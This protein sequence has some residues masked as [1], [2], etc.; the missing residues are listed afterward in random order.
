MEVYWT[1]STHLKTPVQEILHCV[2][3]DD[4]IERVIYLKVFEE[5]TIF[6]L[7][8]SKL[9][10]AHP[11]NYFP[12]FLGKNIKNC[13]PSKLFL[14]S[15]LQ[16]SILYRGGNNTIRL[17]LFAVTYLNFHDLTDVLWLLWAIMGL[18]LLIGR[19]H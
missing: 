17:S 15:S 14:F 2:F 16:L 9:K 18:N 19:Y 13:P 5:N 3:A 4:G 11:V 1:I 6:G 12:E 7:N 10:A 8:R